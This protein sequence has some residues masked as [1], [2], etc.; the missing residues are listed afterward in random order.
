MIVFFTLIHI[1]IC[2]LLVVSILL[3]SSKGG[4][5]AGMLGGGGGMG[6]V[7]GGRGAASFLSKVTMW[8]AV[9][10]AVTTL[11]IALLT[12]NLSTGKKSLVQKV[13][14]KE[15]VSSPASI[16]PTVADEEPIFG[17]EAPES[18]E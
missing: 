13:L 15:Q 9:G 7:F 4:G 3:Q 18:S 10:F 6:N 17:D 14:E 12:G 5:L 1:F 2:I 8:L 16:L 11:S